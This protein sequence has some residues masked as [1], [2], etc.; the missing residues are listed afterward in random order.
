MTVA[1]EQA[2]A[3]HRRLLWS[4]SYRMTGNAAD[5]DEIVQ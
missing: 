3:D 5:A 1:F 4:I 2:F